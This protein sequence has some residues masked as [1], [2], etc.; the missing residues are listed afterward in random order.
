MVDTYYCPNVDCDFGIGLTEVL[1]TQEKCPKC[2]TQTRKLGFSEMVKLIEEKK[3]HK[4]AAESAPEKPVETQQP[5]EEKEEVATAA[6]VPEAPPV[7][8]I[9][10]PIPQVASEPSVE[11]KSSMEA[12]SDEEL[13]KNVYEHLGKLEALEEEMQQA[14]S[15]SED[16]SRNYELRAII[17][18]NKIMIKQNELILRSLRKLRTV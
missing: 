3:K 15:E 1:K 6:P 5:I 10:P 16:A 17:E 7:Q 12:L 18:Q 14:E 13:Q 2:G 4:T 9:F 8:P 11:S